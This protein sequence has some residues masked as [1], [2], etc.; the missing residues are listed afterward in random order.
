MNLEQKSVETKGG[1]RRF[2][3]GGGKTTGG[4]GDRSP[5]A[6]S[7]GG[8]PVGGLEMESPRS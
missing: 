2:G 8:A 5:P 7:R 4:L 3:M 1:G 6:G